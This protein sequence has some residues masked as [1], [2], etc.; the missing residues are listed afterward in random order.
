MFFILLYT[1]TKQNIPLQN[2]NLF[3]FCTMSIFHLLLILTHRFLFLRQVPSGFF[4]IDYR[5]LRD[6]SFILHDRYSRLID[7]IMI[8]NS[9]WFLIIDRH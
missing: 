7:H 3:L 4:F 9:Y 6:A 1:S 2:F 5:K 8:R